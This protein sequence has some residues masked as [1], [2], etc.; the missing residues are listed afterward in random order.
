M[1]NEIKILS[2]TYQSQWESLSK[3]NTLLILLCIRSYL[4]HISM[5][6]QHLKNNHFLEKDESVF[7]LMN[8]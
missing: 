8:V 7:N 4:L 3:F 5:Q 1:Q 2:S 6:D